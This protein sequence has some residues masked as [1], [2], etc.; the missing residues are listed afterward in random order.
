M[1]L[2]NKNAPSFSS[3]SAFGSSK[4]C[5]TCF[6]SIKVTMPSNLKFSFTSSSTKN[7][8]ATGAGSAMPVVSTNTQS[9]FFKLPFLMRSE[10]FFRTTTRSCLT[11][12]QMQP[13][14]ISMISSS[15]CSEAFFAMSAS[16]IPTSPN[17]FSMMA[18]FF[19]WVLS[20]KMWFTKVVLPEPR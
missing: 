2:K 9:S 4:C 15:T 3:P 20:V 16:S 18:I 1:G 6:A 17:S 5:S 10:N 14:I 11:V 12:Q 8:C 7:V 19:P 13:F